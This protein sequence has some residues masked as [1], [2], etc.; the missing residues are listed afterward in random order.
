MNPAGKVRCNMSANHNCNF[1]RLKARVLLPS[2]P[3]MTHSVCVVA[4]PGPPQKQALGGSGLTLDMSVV[5][6]QKERSRLVEARDGRALV[7][8][9]CNHL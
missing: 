1:H 6:A 2:T 9:R 7:I 3:V 4:N 8:G 5:S